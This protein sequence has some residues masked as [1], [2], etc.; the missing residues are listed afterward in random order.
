[1][2]SKETIEEVKNRLVKLY[3]PY[4]IYIFG[5]YAWGVPDDESDLDLL[6]IVDELTKDRYKW[7]ADGHIALM[8]TNISKDLLLLTKKE[9]E[10]RSTDATSLYHRIKNE[11]KKVYARV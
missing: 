5:R 11:G 7:L 1:M 4:E 6:I 10:D 8:G 9:F 2:I 3:N